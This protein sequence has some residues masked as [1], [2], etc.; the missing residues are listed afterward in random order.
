MP[1]ID[2]ILDNIPDNAYNKD[3]D[4]NINKILS[5]ISTE[6]DDFIN[7]MDKVRNAKFIEYASGEDLDKLGA[8]LN[9]KRFSNEGDLNF[10][11][12][13]KARVPSFIGGG[14]I[15]S[16]KQV[17]QNFLGVEP[18]I[19]EHYKEGEGHA[20]FHNGVIKGLKL[21]KISNNQIEI[22][23]GIYYING[24]RFTSNDLNINLDSYSEDRIDYIFMDNTGK[25]AIRNNNSFDSNK[26]IPLARINVDSTGI[27]IED[28][29]FKLNPYEHY[30]TNVATI[31]IQL[32]YEF[33]EERITFNE[34]KNII[35]STKAAGIAVLMRSI[36]VYNESAKIIEDKPSFF[37]MVG[38]SGMNSGSFIGG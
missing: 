22:E 24:M 2:F 17:I 32:P 4:S 31:T 9:L 5:S 37:F 38:F 13:I 30:I 3:K 25:P 21:S 29:R 36:G 12:R 20:F 34:I 33:S 10:R 27:T 15:E 8:L 6:L 28:A 11:G 35:K 7:E 18:I 16:I 26:E 19:I 23:S 14:T 1:K